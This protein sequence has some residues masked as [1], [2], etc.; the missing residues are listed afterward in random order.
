MKSIP[1]PQTIESRCLSELE[2]MKKSE[3]T[4][5]AYEDA[6]V[7]VS[8]E[9][10]RMI[11]AL[12]KKD[13]FNYISLWAIGHM[14]ERL[15]SQKPLT[16]LTGNPE[17]WSEN[18]NSEDRD[19]EE[20]QNLRCSSV[21]K[22][23]SKKDGSVTYH[24]VGRYICGYDDTPNSIR[25]SSGLVNH[26]MPKLFPLEF[27]YYPEDPTLV[28]ISDC[29]F[30]IRHGDF[31]TVWVKHYID[32]FLGKVRINVYFKEN[33]KKDGD[34]WKKISKL[35]FMFRRLFHIKE[36]RRYARRKRFYKRKATQLSEFGSGGGCSECGVCDND[37]FRDE[38]L[39]ELGLTDKPD[40][41]R[42]TYSVDPG[43]P[44]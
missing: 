12:Y 25:F 42:E 34:P 10:Q 18:H 11:K 38:Y 13:I 22:T 7:I 44:D 32:P 36:E 23:V 43:E 9:L 17:E 19:T 28:I 3:I 41:I 40:T 14:L 4:N 26:L 21:F 24:D 35:E 2:F 39:K 8:N 29:L 37:F 1:K 6:G 27:P 20:Y 16:P 30:D 31:D 15:S 33:N 5:E